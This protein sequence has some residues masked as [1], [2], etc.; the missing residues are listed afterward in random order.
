MKLV[1]W[2]LLRLG[3]IAAV[4]T[5]HGLAW[6]L[7]KTGGPRFLRRRLPPSELD[8]PERLRLVLEDLGGTFVKFGQMLALQPDIISIRYCNALFKLLDRVDPFPYSEVERIWTEEIGRPPE[9]VFEWIE[10]KPLATASVGQVHVAR[11]R[12]HKV[13]VKVQRPNV[14]F[15]FGSDIRMMLAVTGLIRLLRLGFLEWL[16]EPTGEFIAWTREEIDYRYEARYSERVRAF[17]RDNPVQTVPAVYDELTTARTLVVEFLEGSTLIDYLRAREARDEAAV[18]RLEPPGF[19]RK[20][21][22]ANVI[23]NF[24]G[25]AFRNGLYHADLHPANLLILRDSVVGYIDFGI[26]GVM[27]RHGRRHLVVMTLALAE[28]DMDRLH[29]EFLEIAAWNPD[30]QPEVFRRGLDRLAA[31]WYVEE[32]GRREMAVNFTRIMGDMLTLSRKTGVLPERDIVKYIRSAIAIDGLVTRFEPDFDV[33][34]YLA[35]V[36]SRFLAWQ[37]RSERFAPE[38]LLDSAAAG[39]RLLREGPGKTAE[40]IDRLLDGELPVRLVSRDEDGRELG[41]RALLL[42]GAMAVVALAATQ[43]GAP[44]GWGWNLWTVEMGFLAAAGLALADTV[45][46]L[47]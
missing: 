1:W 10:K 28:G 25:D 35:Q 11:Y 46:R 43:G 26:T 36:C 19:D 47:A 16:L 30:A 13:A 7:G 23:D 22:A 32:G 41:R 6:V 42:G 33:G 17:A 24:L 18:R 27:S 4:L 40:L 3:H 9:E 29:E 8:G 44:G 14:E 38:R 15:Q 5:R 34:G 37:G 45:R 39:G 2:N 20:R 12:G 31:D 21:F